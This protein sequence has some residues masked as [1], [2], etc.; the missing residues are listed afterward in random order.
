[1]VVGS[2]I[3]SGLLVDLANG[4]IADGYITGWKGWREL[5]WLL[6]LFGMKEEIVKFLDPIYWQ[7]DCALKF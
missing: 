5:Y 7:F 4:A 2:V 3:R 1:M 6:D